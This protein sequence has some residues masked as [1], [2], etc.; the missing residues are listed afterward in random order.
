MIFVLIMPLNLLKE[1]KPVEVQQATEEKVV[2]PLMEIKKEQN[3][4]GGPDNAV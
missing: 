4:N 2:I 1:T 3:V